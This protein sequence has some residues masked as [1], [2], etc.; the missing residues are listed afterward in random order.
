M[1]ETRTRKP[2]WRVFHSRIVPWSI[3]ENVVDGTEVGLK[4]LTPYVIVTFMVAGLTVVLW[5]VGYAFTLVNIALLYLLPVLVSAVRWG[6]WPSFYAAG[7][8]VMA[9]DFFFVPPVFTF[10]VGD[11]RYFISFFVFLA[12]ATLTASLASELRERARD[13][14]QREA[15]T[16]ALY[17]L[18]RQL[19]AARDVEA[20]LDQIVRQAATTFD[21]P[22][23][24]ALPDANGVLKIRARHGFDASDETRIVE[25]DILSWVYEHG[26]MAGYGTYIHHEAL[27]LYV[28]LKTETKVHGV[29]CVGAG[30]QRSVVLSENRMRVIEALAGLAAVSIARMHFEEEAKIAHLTAESERLRTALLDSISHELRTPLATIIGAVTGM[31]ENVDILSVEDERE[32]LSTI[33]EGAMRMNRL[34]T[35][36]LGMVRLESGMLRLNKQWCDVADIVGVALRHVQ[37]ALQRRAVNVTMQNSLPAIHVDD[38]WIEQVLVNLLSNAIKYSPDGSEIQMDVI[39]D[40]GILTIRIRDHGIGIQPEE[41]EKIFEKF[42]RS[43]TTKDI[44]GTGLGLAICK[45]VIHAHGGEIFAKPAG[46]VGTIVTIRLPVGDAHELSEDQ[47]SDIKE[48]DR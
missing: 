47:T 2:K 27:L 22:T 11:M 23:A 37:G 41:E 24:I 33:H 17:A 31:I 48:K 13:A 7:L 6:T 14:K 20:V 18:S 15:V 9:F 38:V 19:A 12:V 46:D 10:T 42:Y 44:P 39:E 30:R 34:V 16:S 5:G 45:G 3:P 1:K 8:G 40:D 32:L 43:S 25:P 36:L 28:P 35:N 21:L 26:Q 4:R 29:M